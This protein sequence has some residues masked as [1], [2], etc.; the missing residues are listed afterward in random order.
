MKKFILFAFLG[1]LL[2]GFPAA[3][4]AQGEDTTQMFLDA[5]EDTIS[6]DDMDPIFYEEE[7]EDESSNTMTYAIIGGIIVIGGAAWYFMKKKKQ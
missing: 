7:T 1:L 6:I 2:A 4:F 5:P 3:V